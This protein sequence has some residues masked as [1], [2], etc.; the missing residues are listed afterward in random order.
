MHE[1]QSVDLTGNVFAARDGL[2][3]A[4]VNANAYANSDIH[5]HRNVYAYTY[6]NSNGDTD[7]NTDSDRDA[8]LNPNRDD[9]THS[10]KYARAIGCVYLR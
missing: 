1:I 9:Y 3:R 7:S 6:R 4:C 2:F 10:F 8:D 5:S